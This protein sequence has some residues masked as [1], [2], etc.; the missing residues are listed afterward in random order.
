[1]DEKNP[2]ILAEVANH[3][4]HPITVHF[5]EQSPVFQEIPPGSFARFPLAPAGLTDGCLQFFCRI[6]EKE[7]G[8]L[9]DF[10][11]P[12]TRGNVR[13]EVKGLKDSLNLIYTRRAEWS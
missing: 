6:R 8:Y 10:I 5:N 11:E 12:D 7:F 3:S 13:F 1:M 2:V 9:T 4:D